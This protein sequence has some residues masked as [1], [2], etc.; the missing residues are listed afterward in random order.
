MKLTLL[1][2]SILFSEVNGVVVDEKTKRREGGLL[3][4]KLPIRIKYVIQNELNLKLKKEL[5]AMEAELM[6]VFKELGEQDGEQI[7]IK[8]ENH[9]E[10]LKR[11][12]EIS[13]IEVEIPVPDINIDDLLNIETDEYWSVLLDK[14]LKK[15]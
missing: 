1:E 2:V 5:E 15:E 9:Q 12:I 10:F 14:L 4:N 3:S 11:Q 7:I 6:E 8:E 13:N